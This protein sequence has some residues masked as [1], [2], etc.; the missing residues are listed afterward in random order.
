MGDQKLEPNLMNHLKA[1]ENNPNPLSSDKK[2]KE[3]TYHSRI[4]DDDD[5]PRLAASTD[6]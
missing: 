1:S 4:S 5:D 2:E 6:G 3:K